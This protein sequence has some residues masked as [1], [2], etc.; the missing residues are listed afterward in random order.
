M[1]F[2]KYICPVCKTQFS[3]E[4]DVVVCPDCGTP[5]HRECWKNTGHCH[6]IEYHGKEGGAPVE[7]IADDTSK[8]ADANLADGETTAQTEDFTENSQGA[9]SFNKEEIENLSDSEKDKTIRNIFEEFN[10]KKTDEVY[11]DGNKI[12]SIE[13]AIGKNQ[14]Y[15]IPRFMLAEKMKKENIFNPF[16]FVFPLAW[17]LYRK[18]YKLSALIFAIYFG[19]FSLLSYWILSDEEFY[20]ATVACSQEDPA[21]YS[22]I[23]L[24]E[25]GQL[26]GNLT[27]NQE[28]LREIINETELPQWLSAM[29]FIVDLAIKVFMGLR[30]TFL[31]YKKLQK[32][33][34]KAKTGGIPDNLLNQIL[35][36]KYG[37]L[38]MAL[39]VIIGFFE[40]QLI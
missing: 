2:S 40:F 35:Y 36:K 37:T 21:Y 5:H 20:E 16:A 38:P 13:A 26:E 17:S 22:K 29:N 18:M 23:F 1:D 19:M 33:I 11:L 27:P 6:N 39:V 31:Y 24:Y 25:A 8:I 3:P 10:G 30:G 28:N 7:T 34:K 9:F 12:S 32:N 4:D 14:K 15:Y